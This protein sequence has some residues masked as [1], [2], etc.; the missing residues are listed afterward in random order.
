M[1]PRSVP[2]GSGKIDL[3]SAAGDMRLTQL[4]HKGPVREYYIGAI[5]DNY[6]KKNAI[7]Y[8]EVQFYVEN[9]ALTPELAI[10]QVAWDDWLKL[11]LNGQQIYHSAPFQG[12]GYGDELTYGDGEH[13][14]EWQVRYRKD[15]S[16]GG[17]GPREMKS[18][19][20]DNDVYIDLRPLLKQGV[21]KLQFRVA[22]YDGGE[23]WVKIRTNGC[24]LS[25]IAPPGMSP[26]PPVW[27]SKKGVTDTVREWVNN[28]NR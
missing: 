28:G 15:T 1:T 7:Y 21:N 9:P 18:S 8:R 5:G 24:D 14:A 23:A 17:C 3:V 2:G 10:V 20:R 16:N 6:W 27:G 25:H 26:T 13:C 22:V 19:W 12:R 4:S 11:D